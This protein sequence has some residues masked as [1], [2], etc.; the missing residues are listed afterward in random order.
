MPG[1]VAGKEG[2]IHCFSLWLITL[3]YVVSTGHR[4]RGRVVAGIAA[5]TL[6]TALG[7]CGAVGRTLSQRSLEVIFTADHTA[8]DVSRVREH[9]NGVGGAKASPPG[10]DN[11]MNR[12]YP[13]RFD[14]SGLSM[15]S[16]SKV[17]GCLSADH[18]VRG[19]Q[20]SE[21]TTGG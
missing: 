8:A 20:D 18:A 1:D 10:K 4:R 3:A 14:I 12:R 6:A 16:R 17:I 19:Y 21:S 15:Q 11:A 7:G 9:C 2:L 13:L 5:V